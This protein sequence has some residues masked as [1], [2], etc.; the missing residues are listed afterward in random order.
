MNIII[1][2]CFVHVGGV[3]VVGWRDLHNHLSISKYMVYWRTRT[4]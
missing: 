3:Q 2:I 1:L 4:M